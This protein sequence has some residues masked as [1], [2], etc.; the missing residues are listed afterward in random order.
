MAEQPDT[1]IFTIRETNARIRAI[2]ERETVGKPFWISGMVRKHFVSDLGHEYFELYDDDFAIRC[3]LRESMRGVL[4]FSVAHGMELEVY[5]TVRVYEK[6]ARLEI[7]VENA[8]WIDSVLPRL[9]EDVQAR[10]EKRGLW[11]KTPRAWPESIRRIGLITSQHSEAREDFYNNYRDYGGKATITLKDVRVQGEQAP[12]EIA[13]MIRWFNQQDEDR[14]DV[15]VL[16]RGGGRSADLAVFSDFLVAEEICRSQIPVATGIG[17][18]T[19]QTFADI[20]ADV[21]KGTPTAIAIHLAQGMPVK[22]AQPKSASAWGN[23][24]AAGQWLILV[25]LVIV[26]IVVITQVLL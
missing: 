8:H 9:N 24:K 6:G 16:T 15:I 20:A 10:L 23:L 5:G 22:E 4:P 19:N 1:K 13:D 7:E 12:R 26:T 2:V 17:H 25:I 21:S 3:M 18:E 14:V 11:P